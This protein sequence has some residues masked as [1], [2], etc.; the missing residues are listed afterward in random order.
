ML[1]NATFAA[2]FVTTYLVAYTILAQ[3]DRTFQLAFAM[4]LFGPLLILWMVYSVLKFG[5][6]S[7][8]DLNGNE[9]GYQDK[10]NASPGAF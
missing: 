4:F 3:F 8:K 5:K 6:Y 7:G 2:V 1:K 9:Y 10:E